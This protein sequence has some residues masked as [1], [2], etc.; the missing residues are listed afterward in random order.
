MKIVIDV[1][2]LVQREYTGVAS[3]IYFLCNALLTQAE[4]QRHQFTFWAPDVRSNPFPKSTN[5]VFRNTLLLSRAG[6]EYLWERFGCAAIAGDVDIFHLPYAALPPPRRNS[7]TKL[8]VTIYDLAFAYYPETA[9]DH[10]VFRYLTDRLSRQVEQADKILTISQSTRNDL[11]KILGAPSDKIEVIYPGT[12]LRAPTVGAEDAVGSEKNGA[13]TFKALN[14]PERYILCVGTWEPRKNLET[15]LKAF[16]HLRKKCREQNI[17]LCLC[18]SK[19]WKYREAEK[20]ITDLDLEERVRTLGYVP[21]EAMPSLF[22]R[23]LM[24][25]YPSLYEG[26]GMP[27]VEAMACGAPVITSNVSS[28]PE[29]AGDAGLL[30]D[31]LSVDD[32]AGAMERLVDD[33]ELRRRMIERGF[34]QARRFSWQKAAKETLQVYESLHV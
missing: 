34:A 6:W 31:P 8:A 14:L 29:A 22:A 20:I 30:I 18:G 3:F 11:Q 7:Q 16:H 13:A 25:V 26:F 28:M 10:A 24:F 15:L 23:S 33:E 17:F 32:L 9:V 4:A 5:K 12:D 19:G 21:R 2:P 1:N 27:V